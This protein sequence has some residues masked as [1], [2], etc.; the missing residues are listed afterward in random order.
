MSSQDNNWIGWLGAIV[1]GFLFILLIGFI[2][3]NPELFLFILFMIFLLVGVWALLAW[4][5][6]ISSESYLAKRARETRS[7]GQIL[8]YY[9]SRGQRQAVSRLLRDFVPDWPIRDS[10]IDTADEL[11]QLQN[12][13]ETAR[14]H[15]VSITITTSILNGARGATAALWSNVDK[16]VAGLANAE[17]V[18]GLNR[19]LAAEV[20]K[21]EDIASAAR[22]ARAGLV[23]AT[24]TGNSDIEAALHVLRSYG[25]MAQDLGPTQY[26]PES[27]ARSYWEALRNELHRSEPNWTKTSVYVSVVIGVITLLVSTVVAFMTQ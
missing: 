9:E 20:T 12:S 18:P 19:I 4:L 17:G 26:R 25:S 21:L 10:L 11:L 27:Q 24:I 1:V 3:S 13:A 7:V 15:G 22:Q 5:R 8:R 6:H 2:F 23:E 14:R 16:I